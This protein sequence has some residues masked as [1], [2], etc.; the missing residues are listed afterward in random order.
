MGIPYSR[1]INA[2]FEQVTPLVAAGF[3]V[4]RTTK[5]ISILLAIIQVLTV[6][7]MFLVFLALVALMYCVNPDLEF[8]KKR[9]L[10]IMYDEHNLAA[11]TSNPHNT[12]LE[13]IRKPHLHHSSHCQTFQPPRKGETEPL[14]ANLSL[15]RPNAQHERRELITPFLRSLANLTLYSILKF[16]LGTV[17]TFTIS[18]VTTWYFFMLERERK[19]LE[20]EGNEDADE[21]LKELDGKEKKKKKNEKEDGKKGKGKGEEEED[22]K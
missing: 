20:H 11:R 21:A 18:G 8:E 19:S 9:G 13:K 15:L 4:L 3:K 1:E 6:L 16:I 17:F 5:N 12:S 10:L 2:A 14:S 7:L 22:K